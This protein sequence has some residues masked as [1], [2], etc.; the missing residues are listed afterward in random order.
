MNILALDT[1]NKAMSV[2]V[3]QD[4]TPLAET[5]LNRMKTHSEQ[6]LPTVDNLIALSGLTP[7]DID[8]VVVAAGP[9]SYTGLRI[10]VTTAKTLAY[11]LNIELVGVSS[12]AV[13]A[14][15][16]RKEAALIVPVMDARRS[17]VFTGIYQWADDKLVNVLLDRHTSL[18]QLV[19][20][21]AALEQPAIFVGTTPVM[22]EQ[23]RS[24][25]G[26]QAAFTDELDNLPR[27]SRAAELGRDLPAA[28]VASFV[29]NYLR[30]TEA[31][32]NWLKNNPN[33][34]RSNYV[35]KV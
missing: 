6:L 21:V 8:R 32:T 29:P 35:Q 16:V 28:D 31:E 26:T 23:I 9:G 27:A 2:A 24:T 10:G 30:L 1:S 3:M 22:R 15:N 17:N 14:A 13:L 12:L 34:D 5:T 11:T 20:E 25:L 19:K 33:A 4:A 7:D 18:E